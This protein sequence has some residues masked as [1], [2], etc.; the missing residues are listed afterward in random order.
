MAVANRLTFAENLQAV[1]Y[2]VADSGAADAEISIRHALGKT[3]RIYIAN[4]DVAANV[5]DSRRVDWTPEAMFLKCDQ[6]NVEITL[7]IL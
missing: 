2:V 1:E 3:P 7:T 6:A 5:Y 4:T